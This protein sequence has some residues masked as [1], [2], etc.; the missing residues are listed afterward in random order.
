M[1]TPDP[2][3]LLKRIFELSGDVTRLGT[4]A[5]KTVGTAESCTGGLIGAAL[6]AVPGSSGVFHGGII[7]YDNRIKTNLLGVA[8]EVLQ[9]HGAVSAQVAS[10]MARGAASKLDVDIAISV[11]GVAGPGGGTA[12][13]PVGTVWMGL[14]VKNGDE[15]RVSA[16]HHLFENISRNKVRDMTCLAALEA[17]IIAL[18]T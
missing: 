18:K 5:G 10:A 13:K 17:L 7:A 11:T 2:K 6:T 14:A 3:A 15:I 8:E 16:S 1:S 4:S 12:E 9:Q